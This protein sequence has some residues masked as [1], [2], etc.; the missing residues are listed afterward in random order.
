MPQII[1]RSKYKPRSIDQGLNQI[2]SLVYTKEQKPK[3]E[4]L[5]KY[6]ITE[7]N[8]YSNAELV[9]KLSERKKYKHKDYICECSKGNLCKNNRKKYFNIVYDS[10]LRAELI[11]RNIGILDSIHD[12]IQPIG[13]DYY[14]SAPS[15]ADFSVV[16]SPIISSHPFSSSFEVVSYG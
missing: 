8:I 1:E 12:N 6:Y 14:H 11:N 13:G 2:C 15:L 5:N 7:L 4:D 10:Y 16:S 3:T 9:T